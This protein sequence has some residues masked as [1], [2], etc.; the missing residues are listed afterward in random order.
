MN[1]TTSYNLTIR[2]ELIYEVENMI[3]LFLYFK[4]IQAKYDC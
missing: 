1:W 4:Q 3:M 2:V